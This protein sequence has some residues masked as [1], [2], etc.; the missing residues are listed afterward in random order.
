MADIKKTIDELQGTF[1]EAVGKAAKIVESSTKELS[2]TVN[3]ERRKME[4]RS[5]IGQHQ[6]NVT[7]A[8]TR[9]GEAYFKYVEKGES[10]SGV[11]D[12]L[13]I[14]RSNTKVIELLNEQL[15]ALDED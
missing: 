7:K 9:L 14:L 13:D 8:Y 4:I 2:G 1:M 10:M 11:G 12:V 5:Q 3:K 15:K 6:R